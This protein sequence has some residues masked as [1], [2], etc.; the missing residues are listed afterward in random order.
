MAAHMVVNKALAL[1]L[2]LSCSDTSI[3]G[4]TEA[5]CWYSSS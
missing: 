4:N 2:P 5:E 3:T 1:P